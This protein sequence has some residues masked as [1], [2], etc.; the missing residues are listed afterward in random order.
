MSSPNFTA[1]DFTK[2]NQTS[3][4]FRIPKQLIAKESISQVRVSL[5]Q[6]IGSAKVSA[7]QALPENKYRLEFTSQQHKISFDTHG[8]DFRGINIT[9]TPAYEQ[10]T[11]V[12]VDRAPI[13]MPDEYLT[14][15]LAPFGRVVGVQHLTVRGF[16]NVRTGTRMV[17]MSILKP[18]PPE[19]TISNFRCSIK[20]RGQPKYCFGCRSFGHLARLCPRSLVRGKGRRTMAD[21]VTTPRL[22]VPSQEPVQPSIVPA[23]SAGDPV[24]VDASTSRDYVSPSSAPSCPAVAMDVSSVESVPAAATPSVSASPDTPVVPVGLSIHLHDFRESVTFSGDFSYSRR[25]STFKRVAKPRSPERATARR[26]IRARRLDGF[27][28]RRN[29]DVVSVIT[30]TSVSLAVV[31][32]APAASLAVI[33][34]SCTSVLEAEAAELATTETVAVASVE[35]HLPAVTTSN[36]FS[37]LGDE[38]DDLLSLAGTVVDPLASP[39]PTISAAEPVSPT[40]PSVGHIST[41]TSPPVPCGESVA[42]T[43]GSSATVSPSEPS[44]QLHLSRSEPSADPVAS[45]PPPVSGA[46]EPSPD[47]TPE[48]HTPVFTTPS[49]PSCE[50]A[51]EDAAS[52]VAAFSPP[53]IPSRQPLAPWQ[54]SGSPAAGSPYALAVLSGSSSLLPSRQGELEFPESP[55]LF[56]PQ[57]SHFPFSPVSPH[58]GDSFYARSFFS[59]EEDPPSL[60]PSASG[61]SDSLADQS[62]VRLLT[63]SSPDVELN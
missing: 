29:Q 57:S 21:V 45:L 38:A 10:L 2:W 17:N 19:L 14:S 18:I 31:S 58:S 59:E 50:P 46:V 63:T 56:S 6:A 4:C 11:R 55:D 52:S 61:Q 8:L 41:G 13:H 16:P 36:R 42:A 39:L 9:P 51:L 27:A 22:S 48:T 32:S 25:V 30:D 49:V 28:I 24:S 54:T 20:Y 40:P 26:I 12:I 60:P 5:I 62:L 53:P 23:S 3:S 43:C 37:L 1:A 15:S 47:G 7:V 34:S 35:H 33:A 44:L